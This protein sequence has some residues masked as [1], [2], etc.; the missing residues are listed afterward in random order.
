MEMQ[1]TNHM[2]AENLLM[3]SSLINDNILDV[4]KKR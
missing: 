4:E 2:S 3:N 1:S